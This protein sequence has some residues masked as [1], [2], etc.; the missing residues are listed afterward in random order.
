M[1]LGGWPLLPL[2]CWLSR[3]GAARSALP[4]RLN[5]GAA[6]TARQQA[7][8]AW[9]PD[10]AVVLRPAVTHVAGL[11]RWV[12]RHQGEPRRLRLL[13]V[14]IAHSACQSCPARDLCLPP[15]KLDLPM[16]GAA[17]QAVHASC[18]QLQQARPA[19]ARRRGPPD[20]LARSAVW[21]QPSGPR[22]R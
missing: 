7:S 21:G 13:L 11:A 22:C 2:P 12:E 18:W 4:C 5:L 15:A 14:A 8:L 20:W 19:A 10:T 6:C 3:R 16:Q 17:L 9:F 1:R